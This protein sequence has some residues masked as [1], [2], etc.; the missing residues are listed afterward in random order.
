MCLTEI[1]E[2]ARKCPHCHHF[3]NRWTTI[4]YHPALGTCFALLPL[5]LLLYGYTAMF[6]PGKNFE[7]YKDQ[8][9]IS[10]MQ[11]AFGENKS[12]ATVAVLGTIKNASQ[13]SWREIHFHVEFL[14]AAGKR[15]DVGERDESTFRLPAGETSSFKISFR[16]EF[17]ETSYAKP[18]VRIVGA[19]DSKARW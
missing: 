12:N 10:D 13:V 3:Q 18:I 9:A 8:I 4:L 5:G 19:K 1:P 17:P 15:V 7:T 11:I 2:L 14:D 6:D 16:R